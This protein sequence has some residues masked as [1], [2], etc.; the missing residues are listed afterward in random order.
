MEKSIV[1]YFLS[2]LLK[3]LSVPVVGTLIVLFIRLRYDKKKDRWN[4][5]YPVLTNALKKIK[6]LQGFVDYLSKVE[7]KRVIDLPD[8][9]RKYWE[10]N[11][12]DIICELTAINESKLARVILH[13]WAPF[14]TSD[15]TSKKGA[16]FRMV[17][18]SNNLF[19]DILRAEA[20]LNNS[21][22]SLDPWKTSFSIKTFLK[23]LKKK[24]SLRKK[25]K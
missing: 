8:D 1:F 19:F 15:F 18:S 10:K 7:H 9:Q 14:H 11:L 3:I 16:L 20:T 4:L 24:L 21:L 25:K 23:N 22:N 6:E 2:T 13:V 12:Q 17:T 5:C